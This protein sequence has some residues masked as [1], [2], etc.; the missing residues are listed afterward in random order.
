MFLGYAV[1]ALRLKKQLEE[2]SINIDDQHPL[3]VYLPCGVGG[4]PGGITFG[5][6]LIFGKNVFCYFAEPTHAPAMLLGL[7]TGLHDAVS[8]QDFGIDNI[9][10]AD[11][12][13][14]GRPSGFVGKNVGQLINGVYTVED[15]LLYQLLVMLADTEG[16]FLEPSAL[17]GFVG[18]VRLPEQVDDAVHIAWATGGSM[19]PPEI[20]DDFYAKGLLIGA[21]SRDNLGR[22]TDNILSRSLLL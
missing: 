18:P 2:Q 17:A 8:V 6:K 5:L 10:E 1:A 7:M 3:F 13:A 21:E 11:G 12:L 22:L 9:T 15:H 4:S 14:V 19:V 20:M 16:V